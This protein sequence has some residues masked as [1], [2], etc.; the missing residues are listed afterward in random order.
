MKVVH[1]NTTD[2]IGGAARAVYR[3]HQGLIQKGC[4][5]SLYVMYKKSNDQA[6]RQFEPQNGFI[7]RP[8]Q[9]L[10]KK[11]IEYEFSKYRETRPE[12]YESFNTDRKAFGNQF[13]DQLPGVNVINLHWVSYF[14]DYKSLFTNIPPATNVVWTLHDLNAF[15]GG[16][17]YDLGCGRYLVGC[18]ACPQLGSQ[19]SFDLS[20]KVWRRKTKI[21]QSIPE[22]RLTLIAPSKWLAEEARKSPLLRNFKIHTVPNGPDTTTFKP[23][24]KDFLRKSFE[25]SPNDRVVLFVSES[26]ANRRKGFQVLRESLRRLENKQDLVLL[27]VGK[28]MP[29]IFSEIKHIHLGAINDDRRLAEIYNIADVFVIP[30]LQDNLPN[31]AIESL[32]CGTPVVGSEVGGIPDIVRPNITGFL[33]KEGDPADLTMNIEKL[34][35]DDNMR[36]SMSINC[37]EVALREYSNDLQAEKYI[38]IY[39]SIIQ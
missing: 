6:V 30:S 3:L 22:N 10:L 16:C 39:R 18:G 15:T 25:I 26:I 33:S 9:E 24:N 4:E 27:S 32:A 7:K 37:R 17:H 35:S 36:R 2:V 5:S 21:F 8:Y 19:D 13:L 14:L 28:E 23:L 31:T 11:K 20:K 1:V 34:L 12:G 38:E 29:E